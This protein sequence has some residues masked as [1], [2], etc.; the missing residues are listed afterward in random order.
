MDLIGNIDLTTVLIALILF[1]ATTIRSV[2]GFGGG[3][4]AMP[5][6]TLVI[7]VQT[8]SPLAAALNTFNALLILLTDWRKVQ[9]GSA[10]RL[11]LASVLGIPLGILLLSKAYE[12]V[13]TGILALVIIAFSIFNLVKPQ[14]T[15]KIGE[16]SAFFFGFLAGILGAAYN[17]NGP[18]AVIYG[19]LR[20]WPAESFRATLQA[21]FFPVGLIILFSQGASGLITTEVMHYAWVL[22]PMFFLG[23]FVGSKI[24][25]SIPLAIF[26][27]G[28]HLFLIATAVV[29]LIKIF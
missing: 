14:F 28:V 26:E 1:L 11:V 21:Y 18:L 20:K 13:V 25:R 8:A 3:L 16:R 24:N 17:A 6:L 2:F 15:S 29:M 7:G 27:K 4:V 23:Q 22:I 19:T 10:W 5:L 12:A 9:L